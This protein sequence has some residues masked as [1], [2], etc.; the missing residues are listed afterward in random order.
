M[1]KLLSYTPEPFAEFDPPRNDLASS[2]E[3]TEWEV[4]SEISRR[5]GARPSRGRQARLAK[6]PPRRATAHLNLGA[7]RPTPPFRPSALAGIRF[8]T[9]IRPVPF[10]FVPPRWDGRPLPPSDLPKEPSPRPGDGRNEP[11]GSGSSPASQQEPQDDP[12]EYVR[13]A[14]ACLNQALGLQLPIDGIMTR[15]TRSALRMFQERQ[16]LPV[17]GVVGPDTE[18]MLNASCNAASSGDRAT[19]YA[20]V[21]PGSAH[22]RPHS[23]GNGSPSSDFDDVG[24][25]EDLF[26]GKIAKRATRAVSSAARS[27]SKGVSS[28]ARTAYKT[29]GTGV[30]Y[31]GQARKYAGKAGKFAAR[32]AIPPGLGSAAQFVGDVARGKNVLRALKAAGAAG[33]NDLRERARYAEM[34]ASFVPGVGTGVAAALGAAN[35]LAAGRPISEAM[36]QAARSAIPGGRL[37]QA[38]FDVGMNLA[39]GK[40]LSQAA[41]A[42]ARNQLPA[43]SRAAFDTAVALGQGKNL[44]QAA[45]ASAGRVLRGSPYAANALTFARNAAS[46]RNL[47]TAALSS[48][49]RDVLRRMQREMG[50]MEYGAR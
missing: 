28:A 2:S 11:T 27:V 24:Q 6:A 14:Q 44:Q 9:L 13:W 33:I 32:Y 42:A 19:P 7:R 29:A 39:Q 5:R 30:R 46:G 37:A 38:A 10:P 35:A 31:A 17:T 8:P 15:E 36:I 45:Y 26:L 22:V 21:P 25:N 4:E 48:A 47:Q 23:G 43:A 41:L 12:S 40:N 49:G 34:V 3:A 16:G 20:N 18:A 1:N 50:E